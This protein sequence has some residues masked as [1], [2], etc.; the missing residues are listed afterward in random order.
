L[1]L[2]MQKLE[3]G[4]HTVTQEPFSICGVVRKVLKV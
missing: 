1:L 2:Q 3:R 4:E